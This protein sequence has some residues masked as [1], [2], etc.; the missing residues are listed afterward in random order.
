MPAVRRHRR[1]PPVVTAAAVALSVLTVPPASAAD[2]APAAAAT[3]AGTPLVHQVTAV[4]VAAGGATP[5]SASD[6]VALVDRVDGPVAEFWSEQTDGAVQFS[7]TG[8]PESVTT[9]APCSDTAGM[10]QEAAAAVGFR[11]GPGK[12]L[13]LYVSSSGLDAWPCQQED[14]QIGASL[15][16]GGIAYTRNTSTKQVAHALGHNLGLEHSSLRRCR[17]TPDDGSCADHDSDDLYDVMSWAVSCCLGSLGAPQ[18]HAL[19]LLP[20]ASTVTMGEH[21]RGGRVRLSPISGRSGVRALRLTMTM[22]GD[23]EE[24][25][26]EYRPA[27]GR[28]AW[29]AGGTGNDHGLEAGVLIRRSGYPGH[30]SLL[31]DGSPSGDPADMQFAL[32]VGEPGQLGGGRFVVRVAEQSAAGAT[33]TV[34][35]EL[36]RPFPRDRNADRTGDLLAVAPDGVLYLYPTRT[37]G[38]FGA[39]RVVGRGWQSRDL[40]TTVGDFDGDGRQ[41]VVARNPAIGELWLYSGNDTGGFRSWRVIGRGWRGVD[42]LFSPG[43]WNGDGAV[44]LIARARRDGRLLLYPGDG[45][46]G[47]LPAWQIGSGWGAMTAIATCPDWDADGAIDFVARRW[48][49]VLFLYEADGAG[50]FADVRRIGSGWQ[51]FTAMAGIGSW[52]VTGFACDILAR[53]SDGSLWLYQSDGGRWLPAVRVGAGWKGYRLFG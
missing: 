41:D 40:L 28:D 23:A 49:G 51:V 15:H 39:R 38:G 27:A 48:D 45:L 53:R 47:F 18:A 6:L 35:T 22:F 44:D 29:L 37:S 21:G 43:D 30:A 12:H 46:G 13:L 17:P 7:A 8:W 52:G 33:V 11:P 5:L 14:G 1:V 34:T 32:R 16:A 36:S 25:W 9:T 4:R 20:A 19:G 50:G 3:A 42:A 31:L 2:D 10:Y 26:L 24:Y